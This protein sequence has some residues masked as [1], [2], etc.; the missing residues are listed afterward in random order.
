MHF[1][2]KLVVKSKH[3][4][5]TKKKKRISVSCFVSR[6]CV[7]FQNLSCSHIDIFS[8]MSRGHVHVMDG[9]GGFFPRII[10]GEC[11]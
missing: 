10:K 9:L 3:D 7:A 8:R 1:S 2:V 11:F 5:K 6:A 4:N